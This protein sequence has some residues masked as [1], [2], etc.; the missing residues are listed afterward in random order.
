MT[1]SQPGLV[2]LAKQGDVRAIASLIN[3]QLQPKGITA[4]V[5]LKESVLQ[6]MLE[7][8]QVP[9]Q[10]ALVAFIRKGVTSLAVK[11][12]EKVKVYGRQPGEDF[13]IWS[14]DF[15]IGESFSAENS[16]SQDH[17]AST[18]TVLPKSSQTR[19]ADLDG[20][21]YQANGSNGQ[22]RLTRNRV[23]ISR[24]GFWGFVS[25]GLAGE[26]EI[27]ISRITAIQF[28][29][30][31]AY[32]KGYLQFSIPGGIESKGGVFN[33]ASDEN[34]VLFTDIQQADFEEV[35][36]YVDS[37]IDNEPIDFSTL[38]LPDPETADKRQAEAEAKAE[39]ASKKATA[40]FNKAVNP[41]FDGATVL[42]GFLA[43][44]GVCLLLA[45]KIVPGLA[46]I[47]CSAI[48][49]PFLREKIEE[50]VSSKPMSPTQRYIT[51]GVLVL[52]AYISII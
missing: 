2:E 12:I 20:L 39:A 41:S 5:S 47:L 30:Q 8:E 22:I 36:R 27:P 52:I 49:I 6:V 32:T 21:C 9:D 3:R 48:L 46:L 29:R 33:A 7:A 44:F 35:K 28:K 37:V 38:K 1:T 19:N 23:I 4:K 26:K 16:N 43:F 34:T 13:P 10:Q 25:Q 45:L 15:T 31:D 51:I 50:K 42:G 18:S 24:R 17:S 14:Q 11:T 40:E